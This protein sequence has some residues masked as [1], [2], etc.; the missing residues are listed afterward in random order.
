MRASITEGLLG[1]SITE[2]VRVRQ[3]VKAIREGSDTLVPRVVCECVL[4]LVRVRQRRLLRIIGVRVVPR[5]RR[6]RT[7]R[8]L[9]TTSTSIQ[10]FL[11]VNME[12]R[13]A[14][15][16]RIWVNIRKLCGGGVGSCSHRHMRIG[17]KRSAFCAVMRMVGVGSGELMI[18]RSLELS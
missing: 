14:H 8:V 6:I 5:V 17:H 16:T 11:H 2:R 12:K 13:V 10:R 15:T 3:R 1:T 4:G 18:H 7:T 9:R